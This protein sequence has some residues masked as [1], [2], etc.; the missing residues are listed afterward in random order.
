MSNDIVRDYTED[1]DII[2][3]TGGK[4]TKAGISKKDV[5]YTFSTGKTL[6]LEN[7]AGKDLEIKDPNGSYDL[8]FK[9]GKKYSSIYLNSD[10]SG[11][12][13]MTGYDVESISADSVKGNLEIIGNEL[14]NY[15]TG[16]AGNHT[17]DGSTGNDTLYGGNG[18]NVLTG[19]KGEDTFYLA[20]H[21]N[22]TIKDYTENEDYL[23]F[24]SNG[25]ISSTKVENNN[26]IFTVSDAYNNSTEKGIVILENAAGKVIRFGND[27]RD[28]GNFTLSA[29]SLVLEEGYSNNVVD[30][31]AYFAT[32]KTIDARDANYIETLIGNYQDNIIYTGDSLGTCQ[33]GN[34]NDVIYAGNSD[35]AYE[36]GNGNDIIYAGNS[37]G[38]YEGGKGNDTIYGGAGTDTFIYESGKDIIYN[39]DPEMD[40][41][42]INNT[43]INGFRRSGSD[44]TLTFTNNGELTLKKVAD[45]EFSISADDN[46]LVMGTSGNN[47]L[48]GGEGN[49]FIIGGDGD[50]YMAGSLGNDTLYGDAGNDTLYGDAGNDTLYGGDGDNQLY[51]GDGNDTFV[52]ELMSK[53]YN[54]I[55]DYQIGKDM[56]EF[57]DKISISDSLVEY[58]N[59]ML[60]LSNGGT[61]EIFNAAGKQI[62]FNDNGNIVN[63]IF[64]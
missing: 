46:L 21:G 17:I 40:T 25:K 24:Y 9:S 43:G 61:I 36:G 23:A 3:F 29:T 38:A 63:K 55:D 39:Y 11:T 62:S 2:E 42:N 33:G 1:E 28:D 6:T 27:Y 30:A 34:G 15:I 35:G 53:G 64:K 44:I 18:R 47:Q 14:D 22:T 49:D 50:D 5:V 57:K 41:I 4:I 54:T 52:F 32:I 59:V 51:G 26:V 7:I 10:Y 60:N 19:G 45:K 31:N 58:D 20:N 12:F 37:G 48:Y 56:I 13:D 8:Y 16:G